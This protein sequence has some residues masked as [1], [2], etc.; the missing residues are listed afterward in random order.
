[1]ERDTEALFRVPISV[2]GQGLVGVGG[3][4]SSKKTRRH[5]STRRATPIRY[6]PAS[7]ACFNR[8]GSEEVGGDE[9]EFVCAGGGLVTAPSAR[10]GAA[11]GRQVAV[12]LGFFKTEG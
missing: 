11:I 5:S 2:V 6:S 12:W 10:G 7:S 9:R 1:M 4:G 3:R 8:A